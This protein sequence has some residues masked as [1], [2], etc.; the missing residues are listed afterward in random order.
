[1]ITSNNLFADILSEDEETKRLLSESIVFVFLGRMIIEC[2][3]RSVL[4]AVRSK[5]DGICRKIIALDM[6][7]NRILLIYNGEVR[8]D[9]QPDLVLQWLNSSP[10]SIPLLNALPSEVDSEIAVIRMKDH[11]GLFITDRL[12]DADRANPNDWTGGNI[13]ERFNIPEHFERYITDLIRHQSLTDYPLICL[14]GE[15]NKQRQIVNAWLS[16]WRGDLVRVVEV[17]S[18]EYL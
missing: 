15:G 5:I 9:I 1:M 6:Q 2:K 4:Q 13:E 10:V 3:T 11:R 8:S 16:T 17:L 18:K 7:V 14:D 12:A